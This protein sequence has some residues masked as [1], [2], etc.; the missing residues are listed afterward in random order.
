MHDLKKI[1]LMTNFNYAIILQTQP[2]KRCNYANS[3]G[4]TETDLKMSRSYVEI[5][6]QQAS[7]YLTTNFCRSPFRAC[8]RR[9][10][11]IE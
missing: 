2:L 6:T 8:F 5:L 3:T 4:Q 10:K 9:G 11:I 7:F 1:C